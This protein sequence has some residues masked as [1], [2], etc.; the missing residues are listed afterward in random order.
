L[1]GE[2]NLPQGF[3]GCRIHSV[4]RLWPIHVQHYDNNIVVHEGVKI[5]EV[6]G[7]FWG[8]FAASL[9]P[10]ESGFPIFK[11]PHSEHIF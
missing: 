6:L 4:V 7:S 10:P 9:K 8:V 2:F 5:P 3:E 1:K 11:N